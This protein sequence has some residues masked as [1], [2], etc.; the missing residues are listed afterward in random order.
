MKE[1]VNEKDLKRQIKMKN[2]REQFKIDLKR[3][4]SFMMKKFSVTE[5]KIPELVRFPEQID[6]FI[7]SENRNRPNNFIKIDVAKLLVLSILSPFDS[8]FNTK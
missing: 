1:F 8:C 7:Q 4:V 6:I 5:F 2:K 3:K